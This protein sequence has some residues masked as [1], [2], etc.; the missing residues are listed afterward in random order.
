MPQTLDDQKL[1]IS[2]T[3]QVGTEEPIAYT[4]VEVALKTFQSTDTDTNSGTN[5]TSWAPKTH[6]IYYLTIGADN[7]IT[8][9]ATVNEW[10]ST[11]INGYHYILE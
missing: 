10:A 1:K 8:F 4:D 3:I 7:A 9:T 5:I 11:N 2:Y 6:Y